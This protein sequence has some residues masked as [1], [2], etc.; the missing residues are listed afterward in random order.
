MKTRSRGVLNA[1]ALAILMAPTALSAAPSGLLFTLTPGVDI[2]VGPGAG[3][4]TIGG[5]GY[6][7]GA[8][9]L[10]LDFPLLVG[11]ELGYSLHPLDFPLPKQLHLLTAGVGLGTEWAILPRLPLSISVSGGY[12]YGLTQGPDQAIVGGGNPYARAAADLSYRITPHVS[13][14]L[15][16]GFQ[17]FLGSPQPLLTGVTVHIGTS[18]RIP[19]GGGDELFEPAATKPSL[20]N[21]SQVRF[22]EILPVF[23][24]YYAGHPIG[25]AVLE[26]KEQT[27]ISDLKLSVF[28]KGFMDSPKVTV[29]DGGLARGQSRQIDLFALFNTGVLDITEGTK[30]SAE[31]VVEYTQKGVLKKATAQE[32]V[33][34]NHRN[35]SIWDDDRRAA[36]FVTARD[37][38]VLRFSKGI[39][40]MIRVQDNQAVD[41]TMRTAMAMHQALSLYGM[42]YVVDP[43]SAYQDAIKDKLQLDFLQFPRQTL[44]YKA[45]DC[46]DLSILYTALLESVGIETAFIT[47]PGHIYMAFALDLDENQ[48]RK[49]FVKPDDLIV[50]EGRVWVPV[51]VTE[52]QGG[53]LKA[54]SAGAKQWRENAAA[55]QANLYPLSEAW[56]TF[57]PVGLPGEGEDLVFPQAKDIEKS[58]AGEFDRF[59]HREVDDRAAALEKEVQK[60]K[61]SPSAVNKLG[62]L[63]ARFG[64]MDQA[65]KQF[66]KAVGKE[67][68]LPGLVNLGNILYL[69]KDFPGAMSLFERARK[70]EP[71]NPSVLLNIARIFHEQEKYDSARK[72]YETLAAVDPKLAEENR[73]LTLQGD[74]SARASDASGQKERMAWQE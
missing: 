17:A 6:L 25:T 74:D 13:V 32:T 57:E 70:K 52:T 41:H 30:V 28:I 55:R 66:R 43:K 29:L 50:V 67:E 21:I 35:A 4:F 33:R 53:F 14:G 72:S 23:Y 71:N 38:S 42:R 1:L 47:I 36:A 46:D 40:G 10:A 45:G 69:K 16:A 64:I 44:S 20:L 73:Y 19:L 48:A 7:G 18:Y 24:Q 65:E 26:N 2:P 62:L 54:W 34:L 63:Y 9:R 51:E 37:P 56:K 59:L 31:V 58:F 27:D 49:I 15:G 5:G 22:E 39:D 11:A 3:L 12:Y 68:Y 60:S 8:Y 61:N